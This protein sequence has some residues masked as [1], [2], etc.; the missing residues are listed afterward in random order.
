[1][2]DIKPLPKSLQ[3]VLVTSDE[4]GQWAEFIVQRLESSELV[5]EFESLE[6]AIEFCIS[7]KL[8]LKSSM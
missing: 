5:A 3:I 8:G 7:E 4:T 1:M 2:F 6:E